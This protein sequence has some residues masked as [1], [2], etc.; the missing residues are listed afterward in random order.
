MHD[1]NDKDITLTPLDL[2]EKLGEFDLDPCGITWHKTAKTIFSLPVDGL[3][4][5]WYG[6]VWLNPPYSSPAEWLEK[7]AIHGNGIALVLSSTG[8]K[9]FQNF[10]FNRADSMFFLKGRPKFM[11]LDKSRVSIMRDVVLIAYGEYNSEI[12]SKCDLAGYFV[13][14]K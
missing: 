7:L 6:R 11:R 12:L 13:K 9:W 5:D 14:L 3:K 2:I 8:T 10:G 1:V 4:S